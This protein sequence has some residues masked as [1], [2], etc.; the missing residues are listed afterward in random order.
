M[1]GDDPHQQQLLKEF[2]EA[3]SAHFRECQMN[4]SSECYY[5]KGAKGKHWTAGRNDT[6]LIELSHRR[7][8]TNL[9]CSFG[10]NQLRIS[11]NRLWLIGYT[12]RQ[13]NNDVLL[14]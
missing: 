9:C 13:A 14:K 5:Y 10:A 3:E 2:R 7:H 12:P 11:P 1:A 6:I 4:K 8:V